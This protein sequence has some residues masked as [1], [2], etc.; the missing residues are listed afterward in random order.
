MWP[1]F[2][3]SLL[4]HIIIFTAFIDSVLTTFIINIIVQHQ[5]M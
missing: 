3:C 4:I 1:V 5:L 2:M